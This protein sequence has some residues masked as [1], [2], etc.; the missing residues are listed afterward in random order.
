MKKGSITLFSL[1]ALLLITAALFALLEGTRFQ[2]MRRFASLQTETALESA[3]AN[4]NA[5]LWEKYR[6]L[7]ADSS[8]MQEILEKSASGRLGSGTN[9]LRLNPEEVELEEYTRLTDGKGSVYIA[10]IASYMKEN[11]VYE[12]VKEIYSQYES[13]K[14]IL[15][16]SKMDTSNI[17]KALEEME[18]LKI[19]KTAKT[20]VSS[21]DVENILKTAKYWMEIGI[22]NLVVP[23][24]EDLSNATLDSGNGVMERTLLKGKNPMEYTN[25][26]KE[27]ILLQQYMLSYMSSFMDETKTTALS[28]ELEYLVGKSNRDINNLKITVEKLLQIREASNFLYLIS[29]SVRVAQ[30]EAMAVVFVGGAVSPLLI[31][32]VKIG[33]LT[34]WAFGESILDVR[35]ILAGKEISLLKSKESWTLE[36]ENLSMLSDVHMMAKEGSGGLNYKE[37]LG[38]LL[39]LEKEQDIAMYAMNLQEA[40]IRKMTG[41]SLFCIDSLITRAK[42]KIKYSY[43][44]VFPFLRVIDAEERWKYEIWSNAEFGY[45]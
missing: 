9:L 4:Y 19:T 37:Y 22:L 33:L 29:D 12:T 5:C 6:L 17:T 10:N 26:W 27:R 2:E 8:S 24:V 13:I 32:A 43:K 18:Q 45:D 14:Q 44:P 34:A 39:L 3:F 1:I 42:G 16:T 36:L 11:Y 40:T 38:I 23:N 30:T 25:T 31:E 15:D 20:N 28:Y 21:A 41:D 35:A 7:G